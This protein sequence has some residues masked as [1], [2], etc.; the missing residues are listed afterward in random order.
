MFR[1]LKGRRVVVSTTG[2]E[3]F[4]GTVV[5]GGLFVLKLRDFEVIAQDPGGQ[6]APAEGF[7][8]IPRRTITWIQEL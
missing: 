1:G 3:G 6:S 5:A 4:R 7:A 8:R 2:T